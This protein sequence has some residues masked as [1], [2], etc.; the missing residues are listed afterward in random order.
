MPHFTNETIFSNRSRPGHLVIIGGGP[1]GLEMAQAHRR[2]GSEVTVLE[3]AR[4]LG[5]DDRELVD[6]V[7]ARLAGEGVSIREGARVSRIERHGRAGVRVHFETAAGHERID[8][9]HLLVAAGRKANVDD[10][11][12]EAAGIAFDRKGITVSDKLRTTNRR[13]YAIGD[14]AG[15]MQFTHVANYHAGLVTRALLF[16]LP[17]RTN[18]AIVP[19]ATYTDPE[20]AHV[21]MDEHTAR[22]KLRK[23]AIS[24]WP[25]HEN[26]RAHAERQTGGLIKVITDGSGRIKGAGI[27]GAN[28]G[29]LIGLWGLAIAKGMKLSDI[30][31]HVAPYPTL[32]EIGKRAA[33]SHYAPLAR[34]P[35]VRALTSF[36]RKF[37]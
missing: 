29:E 6:V 23:F 36:L 34:A 4:V 19:R 35:W 10:L 21:G 5:Q 31:G 25:Y 9:T 32:G 27:A 13:A 24:R 2:L 1:I 33:T 12:L 7:L 17:A 16:R 26:D 8:G 14:V 15:S 30:A 37:G 18:L 28:A 22:A 3:A 11:G 20:L